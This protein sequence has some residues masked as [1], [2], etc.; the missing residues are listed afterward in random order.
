MTENSTI[1]TDATQ[2]HVFSKNNLYFLTFLIGFVSLGTEILG[3]RAI[4]VIAGSSSI[5]T[6][7]L[8]A[9]V[10]LSLSLGYY[11]SVKID[12]KVTTAIY[13]GLL[14]TVILLL[15]S[16]IFI[17][18]FKKISLDIDDSINV[19]FALKLLAL[20]FSGS[21]FICGLPC[22]AIGFCAPQVFAEL[23]NLIGDT[24]YTASRSFI[25]GGIGSLLGTLLPNIVL[26][27]FLGVNL[28]FVLFAVLILSYLV[29][30]FNKRQSHKFIFISLAFLLIPGFILLDN[31]FDPLPT[32]FIFKSET[33]Y[34]TIY[35]KKMGN[36]TGL[37]GTTGMIFNR[38]PAL[39]SHLDLT[40][41]LIELT[42]YDNFMILLNKFF[43]SETKICTKD[44]NILILGSAGC[45]TS[46]Y[47]NH[48]YGELFTNLKIDNLDLD[49]ETHKLAKKYFY[50]DNKIARFIT[51]DA[52]VFVRNTTKKYDYIIIDLY[53]DGL[54]IP[55]IALTVE[56]F[57][58]VKNAL[59]K[60]AV[61]SINVNSVSMK[62]DLLKIIIAGLQQ[63][64]KNVYCSRIF[65]ENEQ[66]IKN[67]ILSASD[68]HLDFNELEKNNPVSKM[69][70]EYRKMVQ[71]TVK[72]NP[73]F[74]FEHD[75]TVSTEYLTAKLLL[76]LV[77]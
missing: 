76:E 68:G 75:D 46:N 28:S 27:P 29:F 21:F 24:K 16:P 43:K 36:S 25:F 73:E 17:W 53:R 5:T 56:F 30:T 51:C 55:N 71:N 20:S 60:N 52:R 70:S 39:Q 64:F 50:A 33:S 32:G 77:E 23:E 12:T 45:E 42:P 47:I 63:S 41:D 1:T 3:L 37:A 61:V 31:K 62:S 67:F 6:S 14:I 65:D 54:Y 49:S 59:T 48:F 22:I 15:F 10:I 69:E 9:V 34:Q 19:A 18:L 7:N 26:I 40:G 44:V 66:G 38:G 57:S 4:A 11:L 8:I 58:E 13:K 35:I 74:Q 72:C 2:N